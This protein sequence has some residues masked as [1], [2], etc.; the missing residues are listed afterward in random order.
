LASLNR[1][2]GE[3]KIRTLHVSDCRTN[4]DVKT[5]RPSI[6]LEVQYAIPKCQGGVIAA[7]LE[8]P[9]LELAIQ[10]SVT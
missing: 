8:E 4:R 6:E 3:R 9:I 5:R 1:D 7:R 2:N 10:L